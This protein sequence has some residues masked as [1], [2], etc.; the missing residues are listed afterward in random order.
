MASV[1]QGDHLFP[2]A[3]WCEYMFETPDICL[4]REL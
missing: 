2:L 4:E 3:E 1:A